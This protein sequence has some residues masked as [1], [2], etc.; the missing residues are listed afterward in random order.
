MILEACVEC[1]ANAYDGVP[2]CGHT[3]GVHRWEVTRARL[4]VTHPAVPPPLA[5]EFS[6]PVTARQMATFMV[7]HRRVLRRNF[8][9]N[10]RDDGVVWWCEYEG[11]PPPELLASL[12]PDPS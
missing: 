3:D 12:A 1:W 10:P 2:E 4:V 11:A 8:A 6:L 5:G 9:V 7:R